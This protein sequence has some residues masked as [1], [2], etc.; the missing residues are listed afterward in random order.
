MRAGRIL[1][2]FFE[3]IVFFIFVLGLIFFGLGKM[4]EKQNDEKYAQ[5][6]K[7]TESTT[8][9]ITHVNVFRE[10][11]TDENGDQKDIELY[12]TSTYEG[13][14]KYTVD[15]QEYEGRFTSKHTI[16]VGDTE[17]IM[18]DPSNPSLF[19]KSNDIKNAKPKS[20]IYSFFKNAGLVMAIVGLV[21]AIPMAIIHI[22]SKIKADRE[23]EAQMEE[24]E[25]RHREQMMK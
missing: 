19:F 12:Y 9:T 23:Y 17:E 22:I 13:S 21:L 20:G 7:C 6:Q 8:V 1:L 10:P 4:K 24:A 2:V 15:G 18:Y 3:A 25:R 14:F 16:S 5:M 11:V